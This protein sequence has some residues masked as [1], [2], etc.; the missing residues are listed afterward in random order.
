MPSLNTISSERP[1]SDSPTTMPAKVASTSD[2]W[3]SGMAESSD[4]RTQSTLAD[5][6]HRSATAWL[7]VSSADWSRFSSAPASARL[8]RCS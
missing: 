8:A 5:I 2:V 4:D 6:G 7:N 3:P 1:T